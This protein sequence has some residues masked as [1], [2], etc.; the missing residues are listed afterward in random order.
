MSAPKQ[1]SQARVRVRYAISS[2]NF[3]IAW[4]TPAATPHVMDAAKSDQKK[5]MNP[6]AEGKHYAGNYAAD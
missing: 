1:G 6:P 2:H 3:P 4:R 5:V